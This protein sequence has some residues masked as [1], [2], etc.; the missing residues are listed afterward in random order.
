MGTNYYAK[1]NICPTCK[2]PDEE[3][4]IGKSSHGWKFM[5]QLNGKYYKNITELKQFLSDK[6]IEDEYGGTVTIDD[7]WKM[8]EEKQK[9]K[10]EG[11]TDRDLIVI[12]G[13]DF[14]ERDFT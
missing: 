8:V 13:Y 9:E 11:G 1:M 12:D 5:F 4:H 7:F 3:V 14:Y 2:R 6:R 10:G